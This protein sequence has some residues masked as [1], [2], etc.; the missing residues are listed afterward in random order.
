MPISS[1]S[2]T[3]PGALPVVL[4]LAVLGLS[5]CGE[6]PAFSPGPSQVVAITVAPETASIQSDLPGRVAAVRD[7]QIRARVTGIVQ[8]IVFKQGALVKEGDLLFKIDAAQYQAVY[9]QAAAQLKK[10]QADEFAAKMLAK[11]YEPLVEANAVSKQ[12]FDNARAAA[13]QT[14]ALVAAARAIP[15]ALGARLSG[16][17]FGG[18]V[19]VLVRVGDV[20]AVAAQLAAAYRKALGHSCTTM[21]I[22]P[23]DGARVLA[24]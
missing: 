2:T 17:G 7:A 9:D 6:K 15:A 8:K 16:G 14:A 10:A 5:A 21:A 3:R 19:V 12:D 18:S 22:R 11:R 1:P 23:S 4:L 20:E 24:G 13:N